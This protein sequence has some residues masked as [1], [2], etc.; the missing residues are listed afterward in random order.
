MKKFLLS[1]ILVIMLTGPVMAQ[2]AVMDVTLQWDANTESDLAGYNVYWNT[3]SGAPYAN[4]VPTC[5]DDDENPDPALVEKTIKGL[6]RGIMHYFAVTAFDNESPSLESGYSIEV[7]ADGVKGYPPATPGL[8]I[9]KIV[10][11][12]VIEIQ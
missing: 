10:I 8:R 7:S 5:L 12:F 2:T 6:Q 4:I 1:I 9:Q 11:R 3:D